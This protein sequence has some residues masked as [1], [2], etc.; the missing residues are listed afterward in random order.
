[1]RDAH[2]RVNRTTAPNAS[3]SAGEC[4]LIFGCMQRCINVYSNNANGAYVIGGS[5]NL[6]LSV[7][8]KLCPGPLSF[9]IEIDNAAIHTVNGSKCHDLPHIYLALGR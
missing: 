9:Q 6:S 8:N 4:K 2:F 5:V 7:H 3:P 1:M